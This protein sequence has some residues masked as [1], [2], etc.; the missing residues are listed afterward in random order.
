MLIALLAAWT[1]AARAGTPAQAE[2][3]KTAFQKSV[4][5]WQ[6]KWKLAK[7]DEERASLLE[8]RPDPKDAATRIWRLIAGDLSK[9]WTLDPA[10]WF[11]QV[12]AGVSET[13]EFGLEKPAFKAEM[14]SV[15]EA[16]AKHHLASPKLTPM[17]MA[18]VACGD[19][20]SL[21]LLREIEARNPSEEVSG[22]AALGIAMLG[23]SMG[24][25]AL[26]VRERL[27]MLRKAIIQSA[28]VEVNG[29]TVAK[30]AEDELY[31]ITNLSKGR[32]APDLKGVDSGGRPMAL[33]D[34][35]GKVVML[36]FW[37]ARAESGPAVMGFVEK[38]RRDERFAGRNFEVVGVN[39]DSRD[40]LRQLQKEGRVDW[41]NFSDPDGELAKTYRVGSFPLVYVLGG[42][43]KIH[44]VGG[45]G[46]FAELTAAAVLEEG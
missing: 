32:P 44:F 41:P 14:R 40:E 3:A 33:S 46:S 28:D 1:A 39:V 16:V 21:N 43:R 15:R 19:L 22:V 38:L 10:A 26:V 8:N 11:L 5:A 34:Y 29:T 25:E 2:A 30:L 36:V 20:E 23:K 7:S 17:C 45:V 12:A 13:D 27:S 37:S 42:D 6:L 24:D 18:L 9:D 4:E 35:Q 31:I